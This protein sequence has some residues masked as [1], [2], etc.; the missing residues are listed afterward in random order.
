MQ[1]E[2][3]FDDK[4]TARTKPQRTYEHSKEYSER[5]FEFEAKVRSGQQY[6]RQKAERSGSTHQ[7]SRPYDFDRWFRAHYG[8]TFESEWYGSR[9]TNNH[10]E[11]E[12]FEQSRTWKRY[13][14]APVRPPPEADS[15]ISPFD[16]DYAN[17]IEYTAQK[18]K[19][20]KIDD[21]VN[22]VAIFLLLF[23]ILFSMA[24]IVENA[25]LDKNKL[26]EKARLKK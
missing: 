11:Y 21:F 26:S 5:D 19:F 14:K 20:E 10:Q 15:K 6:W 17:S 22:S 23:G 16:F 9:T 2:S 24:F 13:Q 8:N 1:S 4:K 3:P 25:E 7:R 18:Q 12:D